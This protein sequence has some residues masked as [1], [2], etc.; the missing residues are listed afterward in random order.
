MPK[1]RHRKSQRH[2]PTR[3]KR[4]NDPRS[5]VDYGLLP[6][7]M[8]I[9]SFSFPG[10]LHDAEV[11]GVAYGEGRASEL[12]TVV[13]TVTLVARQG[14]ALMQAFDEFGAWAKSSD[15]DAVE[16]SIVFLKSGGYLLA[17][18]PEPS[19]L[20]RRT[21]GY[22]RS[23]R[24]ML[25][26]PIWVK[27]VDSTH[28]AL[29][30][31]RQYL[32]EFPSPFLLGGA[33]L[34]PELVLHQGAISAI[35]PI[36]ELQPILKFSATLVDED[37]VDPNSAASIA[38]ISYSTKPGA[39]IHPNPPRPLPEEIAA[40]RRQM[41]QTHYPVTLWRLQRADW[42][43][44]VTSQLAG[45]GIHPWQIEQA[46]CNI[47]M[48]L[49]SCGRPHFPQIDRKL[50]AS[51]I[52]DRLRHRYEMADG[53]VL[54]ELNVGWLSDQIIADVSALLRDLNIRVALSDLASAQR[55]LE[56]HDLLVASSSA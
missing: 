56:T 39:S 36:R 42:Y 9:A 24:E 30:Q 25:M 50:F 37:Q 20:R 38:L 22:D 21:L 34:P 28:P 1:K 48:S 49:D 19:R 27:P 11:I 6:N 17:L 52:T 10:R 41:L 54:P 33:L 4:S 47:V 46:A 31:L 44:H 16:L 29:L 15:G 13:P 55:A 5:G 53:S 18:S 8:G 35:E 32:A 26:N 7:V 3:A 43:G 12:R 40:R 23:S 14:P 51:F 45:Y 2:E